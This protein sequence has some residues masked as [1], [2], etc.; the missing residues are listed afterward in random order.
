VNYIPRRRIPFNVFSIVWSA[1]ILWFKHMYSPKEYGVIEE[2]TLPFVP[3]DK[4]IHISY[5]ATVSW[6]M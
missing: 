2:M 6:P 5:L 1:V 3:G 4:E